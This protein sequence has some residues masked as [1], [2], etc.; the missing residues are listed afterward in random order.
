MDGHNDLLGELAAD[1]ALERS[2]FIVQATEQLRQFL[3]HHK[4]RIAVL[5]GLTLIDD[6]PDYLSIAPDLTFRSRSRYLDDITGEWIS[7]TEVIESASELVELYNPADIYAAFAEAAREAAGMPAEPTAEGDLLE[8]AGIS[9]EETRHD[10]RGP[11]RRGRRLVGGGPA[12]LAERGRRRIRRAPAVRPRAR[13]PGAEP[14]QR[15]APARRVRGRLVRARRGHRRPDH[16][17]RRRRATLADHGRFP[18]RGHPRGRR[19]GVADAQP[20]PT[21]S[22]SSTTRPTSSAT[23]PTR[24]RRR[25][26]PSRRSSRP[27]RATALATLLRSSETGEVFEEERRAGGS[28]RR[29]DRG[30]AARVTMRLAAAELVESREI[31]P[32]QW[33]QAYHAPGLASG[34]RAGQFVHA[35]PGRFLRD[36]PAPAVL[37]EHGRRRD[38]HRDD[39]FPRHRARHRL[40][41]AAAAWATEIDL[42][43]PL[44]RPFEVDPRSRHLLLVAGGLGMAGVRMLADE[45]IRDGRQ[46]TLLFGAASARE[47]YPSS[48]L[49]DEV[50]YIVAT[51]DGSLGHH[52]YV[53]DLVPEYEAWADQA[54]A[55]GPA[56][57]LAA[58]ARIA[59]GPSRPAGRGCARPQA[60]RRQGRPGRL[61]GGA[62]QGVPPG[63][64][65]AEHGLC[66][67]GVPRV[68]GDEHVG[69]PAAGLP[70]GPGLRGRGDRLGERVVIRRTEK[71]QMRSSAARRAAAIIG[72]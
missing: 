1:A 22:S 3:D 58:L 43:G 25:S 31:L 12:D 5:G 41:H 69:R 15:G 49:P 63:L 67:R 71:Q 19:G 29:R 60:R 20:A 70:R 24:S 44:G 42:L 39:P 54:F 64:D 36:D 30:R 50:E 21:S 35:R 65:G 13:I 46:V 68:R 8:T 53:T 34:S 72:S 38:R 26:L 62:P 47:V 7:E 55:C 23:W 18:C 51:D 59:A 45:A 40:V 11:V 17:R 16:R 10:R 27:R 48:L 61:A 37:A 2:D 9:P 66:R 6:E 33:L 32:G 4:D 56:P 28:R 57:M 14:A 52:G